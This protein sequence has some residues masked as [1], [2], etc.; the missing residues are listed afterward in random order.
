MGLMI[1]LIMTGTVLPVG[2]II[3]ALTYPKNW[4]NKK[5]FYGIRN[6]DEYTTGETAEKIGE[7]CGL[8]R[9]Q[10]WKL[11][12]LFLGI[13]ILLTIFHKM[14]L[15]LTL[16]ALNVYAYIMLLF[17][18]FARCNRSLKA[19]K[20]ELGLSLNTGM[21]FTDLSTVDTVHA[22]KPAAM[23]PPLVLLAA[24][25]V[26]AFLIDAKVICISGYN[27]GDSFSLTILTA[28]FLL[29][30]L[31]MIPIA[32]LMDKQ[33][34]EVISDNS[35]I[36]ANYNRAVKK[37][38]AGMNT[39][40]L[41]SIVVLTAGFL[42]SS[43]LLN[44]E[45]IILI[46][47]GVY[48]VVMIGALILYMARMSRIEEH[49]RGEMSVAVD[50]DD[51]WILGLFYYNKND[52]RLN[53]EKRVGIGATVN[54]AHP[55]G[56][57]V[58]ALIAAALLFTMLAMVWLGLLEMTPVRLLRED[59]RLICHQL[60]DEYEIELSQIKSAELVED[61]DKKNVVRIAGS[62]MPGLAK[63]KFTVN[64]ESCRFFMNPDL[65]LCIKIET[66]DRVYYISDETREETMEVYNELHK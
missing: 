9:K 1:N 53:V 5:V 18:P 46:A 7:I 17:I 51:K 63:G 64:G 41:W 33:K 22:L 30:G 61:L 60:R 62:S 56:K 52:R 3:I 31:M 19:L 12:A 28:V 26:F 48:M 34:N 20:R 42:A 38:M 37:C 54:F 59:G 21:S 66:E 2:L 11:T 14:P 50:D 43:L 32:L 39:A 65:K 49:Y 29:T 24:E 8:A 45:L 6:R 15:N 4:Q 47:T 27:A 40:I 23:V 57:L 44:T 25:F 16:C 58:G 10:A 36:N 13:G 35:T 55:V